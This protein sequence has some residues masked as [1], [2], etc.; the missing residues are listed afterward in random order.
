V[1]NFTRK[2]L[3][4]KACKPLGSRTIQ[5]IAIKSPE[6]EIP[7]SIFSHT[8]QIGLDERLFRLHCFR[9]AI[10]HALGFKTEIPENRPA[11]LSLH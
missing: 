9:V 5:V 1:Y 4:S 8:T 11:R 7:M 10:K 6:S 3:C 2:G